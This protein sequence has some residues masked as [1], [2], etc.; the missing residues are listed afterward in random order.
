[1]D[2]KDRICL[3]LFSNSARNYF[4]LN[5]LTK[6]NKKI[7]FDK[8]DQIV[9]DG[10]TNILDGLKLAVGVIKKECDNQ[11]RSSTILLLSDGKDNHYDDVEIAD[12]LKNMTKGLRLSFT[13]NTFGYGDD[14]DPK[15][16]NKLANIRDGAFFYLDDYSKMSQY[17]VAVL[18]GCLSTIS[19]NLI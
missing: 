12:S 8:I 18:G 9:A 3:I 14:H 11:N 7:L 10:W 2:E 1:M 5:Y 19:K 4:N 6:Q 17:F 16:M 15:I 13:L